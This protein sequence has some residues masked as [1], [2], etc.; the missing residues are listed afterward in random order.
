MGKTISGENRLDLF[1]KI[2]IHNINLVDIRDILTHRV[3][4]VLYY[5]L[6]LKAANRMDEYRYSIAKNS[7]DLM[8]VI[9][10][11]NGLLK[12]GFQRRLMELQHLEIDDRMKAYFTYCLNVKF[13]EN[14]DAD[15]S[16][17]EMENFF[18]FIVE[19]LDMQFEY[20][21]SNFISNFTSIIRRK[22]GVLKRGIIK[23]NF[24]FSQRRHLHRLISE[25]K[26]G[27]ITVSSIN[28]NFVLNGYPYEES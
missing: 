7:L 17:E 13:S 15:F 4:S 20:H 22:M 10:V 2:D 1:P 25:Y 5:G 19:K 16:I 9:L 3:F 14:I 8:T 11:N 23:K 28:D 27:K 24:K 6:P 18:I 26:D 21:L 12:S